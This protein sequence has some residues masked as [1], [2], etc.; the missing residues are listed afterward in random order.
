MVPSLTVCAEADNAAG[1]TFVGTLA[2][3]MMNTAMTTSAAEV[4]TVSSQSIRCCK[5]RRLRRRAATLASRTSTSQRDDG[6]PIPP[7]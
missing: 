6:I 2:M 1:L 4:T 5:R 7:G 3:S